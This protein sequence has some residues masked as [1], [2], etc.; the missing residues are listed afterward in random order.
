MGNLS[1][2][3]NDPEFFVPKALN[4]KY[5]TKSVAQ[6]LDNIISYFHHYSAKD[7]EQLFDG[8]SMKIDVNSHWALKLENYTMW[9]TQ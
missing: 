8:V 9:M 2:C 1:R 4:L 5:E 7:N 3:L 6:A